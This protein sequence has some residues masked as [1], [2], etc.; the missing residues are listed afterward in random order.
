MT[1]LKQAIAEA[2]DLIREAQ[3]I[4]K[5]LEQTELVAKL[6]DA[7]ER[8]GTLREALLEVR[9]QSATLEDRVTELEHSLELK[10]SLVRH[11]GIYWAKDDPD[12][13]CPNC[14]ERDH[15][16]IHL[17]RTDLMAGRLCSCAICQYSVNLD[18]TQP[19]K[20]WPEPVDD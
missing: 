7:R 17:S 19:P 14:W 5:A 8:L 15:K 6:M 11:G 3:D 1:D 13:W 12:P 18:H 10:P 2:V 16:A 20:T 4:A 9:E